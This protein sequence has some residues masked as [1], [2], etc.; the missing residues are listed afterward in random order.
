VA[1]NELN[2][3]TVAVGGLRHRRQLTRG[4]YLIRTLRVF[5]ATDIA[6]LQASAP[7]PGN[8]L[9]ARLI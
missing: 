9:K 3:Q 6:R 1:R 8:D 7:G 5:T 2:R 4:V